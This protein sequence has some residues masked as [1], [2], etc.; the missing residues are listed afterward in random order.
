LDFHL[1]MGAQGIKIQRRKNNHIS[2]KLNLPG[3]RKGKIWLALPD[4]PRRKIIEVEFEDKAVIK[5]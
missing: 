3:K 2:L 5:V 1:G 4:K